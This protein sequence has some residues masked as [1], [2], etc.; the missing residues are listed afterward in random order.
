MHIYCL[1]LFSITDWFSLLRV[2][3]RPAIDEASTRA[4]VYFSFDRETNGRWI[5]A[6]EK[7]R[8]RRDGVGEREACLPD[9]GGDCT[10]EGEE[11]KSLHA[12][13]R[14]RNGHGGF[15]EWH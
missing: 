12:K 15:R 3:A 2:V 9:I 10:R 5:E 7:G 14:E 13:P 6:R 4:N 8:R 1:V 11:S